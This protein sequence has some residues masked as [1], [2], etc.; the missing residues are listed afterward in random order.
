MDF[1]EQYKNGTAK[2]KVEVK[3]ALH[4]LRPHTRAE[5]PGFPLLMP[6]VARARMFAED[7]KAFERKGEL[8]ELL[9]VYLPCDHTQGTKPDF[10]TPPH[11][12]EAAHQAALGGDTKY[13][14]QDGTKALKA[15]VQR[16]FKRDNGLDYTLDEILVGN[17]GKQIIFDAM[18]ASC[19]PGDEV[20]IPTPTW[21]NAAAATGIMGARAVEVAMTFGND[22]WSLDFDRLAAA[23]TPKTRALFLVSPSNP[24]GWTASREDLRALLALARQVARSWRMGLSGG[25]RVPTRTS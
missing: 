21:P 10:P 25:G 6:D 11:A 4:T 13:P 17:G 22:G 16:K 5:Y 7:L 23:M 8:P 19:D 20:V 15:A 14:P 18:M 3:P 1:Y 9:Y 2:L 24:T 12:I